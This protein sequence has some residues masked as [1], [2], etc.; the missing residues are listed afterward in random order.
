MNKL[1]KKNMAKL[2]KK[3]PMTKANVDFEDFRQRMLMMAGQDAPEV[4]IQTSSTLP[5][6]EI[7]KSITLY[8]TNPE[9]RS[10]K[11]YTLDIVR[12]P[13]FKDTWYVDFSYGKRNKTLKPG[14]KTKIAVSYIEACRIFESYVAEKSTEGYTTNV[15]GRPHSGV[16]LD[17]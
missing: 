16:V 15:H 8:Y 1:L 9:E 6:A 2:T 3:P 17:G 13:K 12:E 14:R 5:T 11:V 4:V 7:S 10:D